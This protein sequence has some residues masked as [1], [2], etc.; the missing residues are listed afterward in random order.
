[1]TNWH[2]AYALPHKEARIVSDI[3]DMGGDAYCP[4]ECIW[5]RTTK[6]RRAV[7]R[8]MVPGYVFFSLG[9]TDFPSIRA[10]SG[11]RAF[12]CSVN[13]QGEKAPVIVPPYRDG[14]QFV[15]VM[16][17]REESGDFDRT[18]AK[19]KALRVGGAVRVTG[20]PFMGWVGQLMACPPGARRV[21]ILLDAI[22]GGVR[23][24]AMI[25]VDLL[26]TAA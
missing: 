2:V 1:M 25:N 14:T 19:G 3:I 20:G 21:R 10:V 18:K 6:G 8:P 5:R 26:E 7:Y 17:Q 9:S 22:G 4:M 23:T 24:P 13:S 16:R 11:V 15:D 12:M